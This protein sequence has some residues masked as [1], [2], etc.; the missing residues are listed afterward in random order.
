M[1]RRP[2][3]QGSNIAQTYT[4]TIT[5]RGPPATLSLNLATVR[6]VLAT[7]VAGGYTVRTDAT[8]VI[9][10]G[11]TTN[12]SDNVT[13][14]AVNTIDESDRMV[15]VTGTASGNYSV[16]DA[17]LTITNDDAA[18]DVTLSPAAVAEGYGVDADTTIVIAA[19]D[20]PDRTATG[21]T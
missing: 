3:A 10:A 13:I 17:T 12:A 1:T 20:A 19:G 8:V 4:I 11:S 5:R 15:S 21:W 6:V 9:G 18:P 14:T 16:I 7:P 2:P